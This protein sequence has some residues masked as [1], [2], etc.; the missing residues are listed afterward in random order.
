MRAAGL[1]GGHPG[2][3]RA[4]TGG[5]C[6]ELALMSS[7]D[8]GAVGDPPCQGEQAGPCVLHPQPL[9]ACQIA[10]TSRGPQ[11]LKFQGAVG[12]GV[13]RG[14]VQGSVPA[15]L[16]GTEILCLLE[17]PANSSVSC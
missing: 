13:G 17:F 9:P 6:C 11:T 7:R 8:L 2:A 3:V 15:P 10:D 1:G 16:P 14:P 12:A 5:R 4:V